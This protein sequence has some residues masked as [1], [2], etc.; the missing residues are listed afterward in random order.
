M[1]LS[2]RITEKRRLLMAAAAISTRMINLSR[3]LVLRPVSPLKNWAPTS[4]TA[5]IAIEEGCCYKSSTRTAS[6]WSAC[7]A[8]HMEVEAGLSN[9]VL[10]G[11]GDAWVETR[12]SG[13]SAH[14]L[15]YLTLTPVLLQVA[16]TTSTIFKVHNSLCPNGLLKPMQGMVHLDN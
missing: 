7:L 14:E 9:N 16:A 11:T 13:I 2:N 10:A 15:P 6:S 3:P 12:H 4:W 8:A 5:M 1:I